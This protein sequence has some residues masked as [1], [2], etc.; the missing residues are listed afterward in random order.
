MGKR[1]LIGAHREELIEQISATLSSFNVPH[2]IIASGHS[3]NNEKIQVAMVQTA[4]RRLQHIAPPDMII[5]DEGHRAVSNTYKIIM[6]YFVNAYLLL[7]TATPKRTDG[8]GLREVADAMVIGPSMRDLISIGRLTNYRLFAPPSDVNWQ[9]VKRKGKDYD[10]KEQIRIMEESTIVG[11]A[12]THYKRLSPDK[13]F[14]VFCPGVD[15][16]RR[17]AERFREAG[18]HCESADGSMNKADRRGM[19]KRFREGELLGVAS[20]DLFNEGLDV[21][22]I[23]TGIFLRKTI[24]EVIA[25]QQ[26]GRTL[27]KY[28][29]KDYAIL[30]D[31]VGN[32]RPK[33]E[34]GHGL[35]DD[36]RTWSL[37]DTVTSSKND[38]E[39]DEESVT[40][41]DSCYAVYRSTLSKCPFCSADTPVNPRVISE[42]DGE[43]VEV[44][45][46]EQ[47]RQ[48][49]L[50]LLP[51]NDARS[52]CATV[53]DIKAMA[54]ARKY[55]PGWII[56]QIM[57]EHGVDAYAAA[58][59]AGYNPQIV[60]RLNLHGRP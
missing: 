11:D 25:V 45:R 30:L 46:R 17:I 53:D 24:S 4:C 12:I 39:E 31:H 10:D 21:P 60:N 38:D 55:K 33:S 56:R 1:V 18:I 59:L 48:E 42:V 44:I 15:Y 6:Q 32:S 28:P 50:A 9:A 52:M 2:G 47:E 35:P 13:Q 51:Y 49:N 43:L 29:G 22:N 41:C 36:D 14:I 58:K 19:I 54:K 37:D 16:S 20:C 8:R 40:R 57:Y 5:F 3:M 27:R 34:G 23:M 7:V 26:N